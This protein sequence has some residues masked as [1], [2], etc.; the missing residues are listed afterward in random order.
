MRGKAGMAEGH[1]VG[2]GAENL[3]AAN[4][5]SRLDYDA[6]TVMPNVV[7][8]HGDFL[9]VPLLLSDSNVKPVAEFLP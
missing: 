3:V 2:H 6:T 5:V 1:E 4:L 8:A 9:P 7:N